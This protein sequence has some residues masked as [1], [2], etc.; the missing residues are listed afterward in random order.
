M[1]IIPLAIIGLLTYNTTI[2]DK[3]LKQ[4]SKEFAVKVVLLQKQLSAR[5]KEGV[6]SD[7]LI[8]SGAGAGAELSKADTALSRNDQIARVYTALQK[9]AEAKYWIELLHDTENITEFEFNDTVKDCD[10]LGK[11][12]VSQ[13]KTLRAGLAQGPAQKQ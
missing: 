1:S 4:K 6:M 10:E 13:I 11:L 8:R 9:C 7:E 5:K 12:L 2:M 3:N